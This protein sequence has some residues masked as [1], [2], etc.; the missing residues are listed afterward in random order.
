MTLDTSKTY[1]MFDKTDIYFGIE[2]L[3]DQV[4]KTWEDTRDLKVPSVYSRVNE[5]V[6]FGMG[7]SALGPH[8]VQSVF[9]NLIKVPVKIIRD[10]NI[11]KH[12]GPKTMVILSSFSGNT[13]EVLFAAKEVRRV[14]AKTA[15]LCAGGKLAKWGKKEKVPMY[16]FSPNELAKEP[17]LGT[18]FSIVGIMS[19]LERANLLKVSTSTIKRMTQAMGDVIQSSNVDISSDKNPAKIVAKELRGRA[20]MIIASEHL[21]GN[22]HILT[23]QINETSKQFADY[24][25]LPELN[26]HLMEGLGYPTKFFEKFTVLM[27]KSDLYHKRTRRRYEITAD[28]F[29]KLGGRVIEYKTAGKT[30]EEEAA[31]LLQF[32][33]FMSYYLAMLNKVDPRKSPYVKYFKKKLDE[34]KK[35]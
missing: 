30:R 28:V 21:V 2:H 29:E 4:Q 17:R 22:A 15:V 7:G 27:I 20:V 32:G 26:H 16:V 35:K 25:E 12:I 13:E 6:I 9:E 23:N 18:G 3:P 5:V 8:V 34:K 33:S 31:E 10:Y 11:P 19:I 1:S 14:R 24:F